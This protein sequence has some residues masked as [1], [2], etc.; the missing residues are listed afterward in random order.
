MIPLSTSMFLMMPGKILNNYKMIYYCSG[1]QLS[2]SFTWVIMWSLMGFPVIISVVI[3]KNLAGILCEQVH[4]YIC[5]LY[6]GI[7]VKIFIFY[8]TSG[9]TFYPYPCI[10][11]VYVFQV[12]LNSSRSSEENKTVDRVIQLYSIVIYK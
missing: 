4:Q 7:Y 1:D 8:S 3:K 10:S 9:S 5:Q 12:F 11:S 6:W 2:L